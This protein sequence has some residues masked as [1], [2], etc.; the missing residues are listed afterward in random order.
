M[1]MFRCRS[2]L[3]SAMPVEVKRMWEGGPLRQFSGKH[4]GAA[5]NYYQSPALTGYTGAYVCD[6]CLE[7]RD[8]VYRVGRLRKWLCKACKEAVKP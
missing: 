1:T 5:Q 3:T 4:E 7:P 6:E 8:G 2:F